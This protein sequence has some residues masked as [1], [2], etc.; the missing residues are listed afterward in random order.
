MLHGDIVMVALVL[1]IAILFYTFA[2]YPLLM[3]LLSRL[4]RFNSP[5]VVEVPPMVSV[6]L[7]VHNGASRIRARVENLLETSHPL[8][9]LEI[10]VVSDGSTDTTATLIS[11]LA[12]PRVHLVEQSTRRGKPA[13][14][15]AGVAV[16]KGEIL[17]LCDLRQDYEPDTIPNLVRHFA[18]P[19][20]GAVSGALFIR[21]SDSSVGGGVDAYWRLEKSIRESE[22]RWDSC[23][24]CTG[25]VYAVRRSAWQPIPEDTLIDDV[26]IPMRLVVAGHRVHFDPEARAFDPQTLEPDRERIR[27]QR[28]LAGNYQMLFRHL[29]WL[30]PWR[31]RL[32]WQLI[33]HKYLRLLAPF[34]MAMVF[35]SNAALLQ[36]VHFQI[37]FAGQC[38]FYLLALLGWLLRGT[39]SPLLSLPAGFVFLN[40]M[41]LAGLWH[42]LRGT[43]RQG[44][45]MT[46]S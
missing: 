31:N 18:D 9:Q 17:V 38:A 19:K 22:A 4:R 14:L 34:L 45:E 41:L 1:G 7:C 32:W 35:L 15:N 42:Y 46:R 10:I 39:S 13:A 20:V 44:W 27:K 43:H 16:A 6:V 8:D 30:L 21:K 23:V 37:L 5:G 28:T 3:A 24:G 40:I 2:G 29:D 36:S 12:N 11:E 26:E 25:A 33:S